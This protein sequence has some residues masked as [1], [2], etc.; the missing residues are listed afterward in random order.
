M[1]NRKAYLTSCLL[2]LF[3][4]RDISLVKILFSACVLKCFFPNSLWKDTWKKG[5]DCDNIC[6]LS[7]VFMCSRFGSSECY[8]R[9]AATVAGGL[10][11]GQQQTHLGVGWHRLCWTQGKLWSASHKG[12]P[13]KQHTHTQP[14]SCF[15][16]R[17]KNSIK[18]L[19]LYC[20][21]FF[22]CD[23]TQDSLGIEYFIEPGIEKF[24]IK[25]VKIYFSAW[26]KHQFSQ[27]LSSSLHHDDDF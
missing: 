4:T 5:N 25:L 24:L 15:I 22:S 19:I 13:C 12:H 14:K 20:W 23:A 16:N 21:R 8:H 6:A 2:N 18:K 26:S 9:D 1:S 7:R 11:L 3:L 17:I 10:G 27:D